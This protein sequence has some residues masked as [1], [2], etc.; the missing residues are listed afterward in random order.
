MKVDKY[1]NGMNWGEDEVNL[2]TLANYRKYQYN[3]IKKHIKGKVLEVGSGDRGF[4]NQL[5]INNQELEIISIEPSDTFFNKYSSITNYPKNITFLNEDIFNLS[6]DI[7]GKF[8]TIIFIH[9]LEHIENDSAAILKAKE[10]LNKGGKILIEV[11]A[12]P[13][14]FSNHDKS[15]GH[16]RRYTKKLLSKAIQ[17]SDLTLVKLWYQDPVG[18]LGSFIYFK[19][20]NK[21]LDSSAGT[22]LVKN[23]GSI[24]D[25]YIIPF[26]E[27]L[28]KVI[29][30]PFGLSLTAILRKD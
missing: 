3:L 6:P 24:Y 26:E 2:S 4:T 1:I 9:V 14:L 21:T 29:T 18:V 8:D 19:L 17:Q 20:L 16:Y 27:K 25:K 10:L 30:F 22:D 13:F 23:Q 7:I 15:L 5:I 12:L 28:E 11:P